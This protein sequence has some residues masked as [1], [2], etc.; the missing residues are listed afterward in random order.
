MASDPKI[1]GCARWRRAGSPAG[2]PVGAGEARGVGWAMTVTYLFVP[3]NEE[4]KVTKALACGAD[5]VILDLEDSI[6]QADK[7]SA[8]QAVAQRLRSR[9]LPDGVQVWV[10]VNGPAT[11]AFTP[12]VE[13]IPWERVHGAV[14]P[15][16]EHPGPLEAVAR[17]GA[18]HVLPI[19][20]SVR[21]L[22]ALEGLAGV[23]QVER[24]ALGTWD[25]ALD[26]GLVALDDPDESE[27]IW[28]L[29]GR[30][31]VESRRLGLGPPVD[32]IYASFHDDEGLRNACRR[33]LRMGFGGKLLIHPRQVPIAREVFGPDPDAL[34]EAREVLA[35]YARATAEGRGA[36]QVRG[37]AVDLPMVERARALLARFGEAGR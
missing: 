17:A 7:A 24:V 22:V 15:K 35:A 14:V 36:I 1:Q 13:A 34:A 37:R 2:G 16:A 4:R 18:R 6:P 23:A 5:A 11:D 30:L 27:L 29:R 19:V 32:G 25:L 33:A 8:R 9:P 28:Q 21:G 31:A 10:R 12:D 20:E 26:L 3:G